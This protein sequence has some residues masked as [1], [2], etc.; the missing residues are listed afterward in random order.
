MES[1]IL[2]VTLGAWRAAVLL[3]DVRCEFNPDAWLS[4][5]VTGRWVSS[6]KRSAT[7]ELRRTGGGIMPWA[8]L[9]GRCSSNDS[10]SLHIRVG[11][12]IGLPDAP[13]HDCVGFLG[14]S[15]AMGLPEEF[16]QATLDGLVR[17]RP[18]LNLSGS[19]EVVGAA[20]HEVDS[21]Q[22]AFEHAA[23]LLKLSLLEVDM[24][25]TEEPQ[26]HIIKFLDSL[27]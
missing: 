7:I 16:G 10:G 14:R 4:E 6:H 26:H 18:N 20:Y 21:S 2:E 15:L 22:F 13:A 3:G 5:H 1:E 11:S 19:L 9:S 24:L 17:F 25:S 27:P 12:M 8:L 23:G